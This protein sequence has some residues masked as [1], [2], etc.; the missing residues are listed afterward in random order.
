[1]FAP[2]R[3]WR[4]WHRKAPVAQRRA[5]VASAL[6]ASGVVPLIMARG[7]R[8]EDVAEVPVVVSSAAQ[9][10]VKT[11]AVLEILNKL[12]LGKDLERARTSKKTRTGKGKMR[13]RRYVL[14]RGP[15]VVY[16]AD[17][18]IKRACANLPGVE[19]CRVDGL[20]LLQLAPGGHS[21]RLIV[22]TEDAF[23]KLDTIYGV[24]ADA[25]GK[26]KFSLPTPMMSN[27]D[28][29]R[30][31]NSD[32]VQSV[33]RPARGQPQKIPMKKN[34][35]KNKKVMLALNPAAV[36]AKQEPAGGKKKKGKKDAKVKAVGKSFYKQMVAKD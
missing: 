36:I 19:T 5:A 31:I 33:L 2:N 26:S 13:N 9:K 8:V 15:L 24:E 25:P 1:M 6:A 29:S 20:N 22:W 11:A 35:L 4:K 10:T 30:I 18:G 12:G 34:P 17:E 32:E 3:V 21:G 16:D 7:H 23:N 14:R 28:I 27:P